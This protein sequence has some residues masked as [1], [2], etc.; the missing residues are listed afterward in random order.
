MSIGSCLSGGIDSSYIVFIINNIINQKN[1]KN[2]GEKQLV[3]TAVYEDKNIDE[4]SWANLVVKN[5]K[6]D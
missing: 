2:I 3:F 1:I 5:T 6:T 4:S